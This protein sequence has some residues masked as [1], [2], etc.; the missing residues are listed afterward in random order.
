MCYTYPNSRE[1]SLL[2]WMHNS[3]VSSNHTYTDN[4]L[5]PEEVKLANIFSTL[6]RSRFARRN[7]KP[8]PSAECENANKLTSNSFTPFAYGKDIIVSTWSHMGSKS[9]RTLDFY[10]C[11]YENSTAEGYIAAF[12]F[13]DA[14]MKSISEANFYFMPLY[15]FPL[16]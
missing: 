13:S 11:I 9:T 6:G 8:R 3:A 5:S 1:A 10:T 12:F 15:S 14:D 7:T 16:F 2:E 4:M